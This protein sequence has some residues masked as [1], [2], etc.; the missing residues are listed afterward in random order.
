[1]EIQADNIIILTKKELDAIKSIAWAWATFENNRQDYLGTDDDFKSILKI[2]HI[3]YLYDLITEEEYQAY[4]ESIKR[5]L[6]WDGKF[7][8]NDSYT[9]EELD[10]FVEQLHPLYKK[11]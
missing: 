9:Y 8:N 3:P 5:F 6:E 1:M 10:D 4:V 7:F 2:L 11:F